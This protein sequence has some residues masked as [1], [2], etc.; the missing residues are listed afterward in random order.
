MRHKVKKN[1]RAVITN[2]TFWCHHLFCWSI[3]Y[4]VITTCRN[5]TKFAKKKFKNWKMPK[6][7][8]VYVAVL[9]FFMHLH[10]IISQHFFHRTL[11]FLSAK[12]E[13]KKLFSTF[14]YA[15]YAVCCTSLICFSL[16]KPSQKRNSSHIDFSVSFITTVSEGFTMTN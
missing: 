1:W 16:F 2:K 9:V 10:F 12:G 15:F 3:K 11:T 8:T 7:K 6:F 5:T 4:T 14:W 13:H